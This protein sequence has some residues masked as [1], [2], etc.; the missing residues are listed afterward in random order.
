MTVP[1]PSRQAE[2]LESQKQEAAEHAVGFV[3]SGMV[4]GLGA[5]STAWAAPSVNPGRPMP[6]SAPDTGEP[7]G[8]VT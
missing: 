3:E 4:V 7:S 5:G 2:R 6:R 8:S 1:T